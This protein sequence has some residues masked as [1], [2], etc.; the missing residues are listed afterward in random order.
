[1]Q[2]GSALHPHHGQACLGALV[3]RG[4]EVGIVDIGERAPTRG[5]HQHE[6]FE[7]DVV[8]RIVARITH[9]TREEGAAHLQIEAQGGSTR[10]ACQEYLT[11]CR[12]ATRAWSRP[13][14]T[15]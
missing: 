2:G 12:A 8:Q 14:R 3:D 1:M 9:H 6:R 15:A 4:S 5:S 7:Q 10:V 13:A 11:P